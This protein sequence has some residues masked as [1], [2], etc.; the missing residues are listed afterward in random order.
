MPV[1]RRAVGAVLIAVV[2]WSVTS[3]FVRAGHSDALVFT[4]WRLWFALPP[5]AAIVRWRARRT[6]SAPFWPD[7]V[8]PLR[9]IALLVGA[10]GFFVAGAA[11]TFA[12]LGHD[13][14]ARRHA[15]RVAAA[16]AD[17]RVRGRVPRRARGPHAPAA[18][19]GRDRG[20]DH[21]G[22][23]RVGQRDVESQRRRRRGAEP[24]LQRGL[25]PLRPGAAHE[26]RRRPVRVHAR[27]RSP[28]P[29]C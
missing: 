22:R 14:A 24:R 15:H 5:L 8:P 16:G 17:H 29:R 23:G 2:L 27:A 9:W 12:A 7:D 1:E 20:N 10:G 3:L 11:T 26:D 6:D 28:R 21:G 4:T 13:A 19:R 18:G 25:V